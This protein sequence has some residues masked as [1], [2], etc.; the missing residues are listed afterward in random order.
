MSKEPISGDKELDRVL[1]LLGEKAIRKMARVSLGK[2]LTVLARSIRAVVPSATT[3]GH[4]NRSIKKAI[5]R[6]NKKNRRHG[7]HEAKAGI[8]VGKKSGAP[9]AHLI[10]LGTD[11]RYAGFSSRQKG[12]RG[13]ARR[14]GSAIAYRG[15]IEANDFIKRGLESANSEVLSKIAQEFERQLELETAKLYRRRR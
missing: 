15:R 13:E 8:H 12:Y 1:R 11:H 9:H 3:S 5:G 6:R 4:S 10:G 7:F 2:G 14:T